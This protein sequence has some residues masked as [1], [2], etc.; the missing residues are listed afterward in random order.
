MEDAVTVLTRSTASV[1]SDALDR[2]G[3]RDQTLDPAIRPLAPGTVLAGRAV[4]IRVVVS[5]R[6]A[7]PPYG[8]EIQAL[9]DLRPGEVPVY[10]TEV[11]VGAAL[12]G[13][14][15]TCAALGRGA[16]GAVLDGPVRDARQIRELGFPVFSRGA[17]PLDTLGR[18]EVE[19]YRVPAVCG[20]VPIE[21]GDVVVADDDVVVVVPQAAVAE[22]AAIVEAKLRDERSARADLL[23][24]A[25]LGEV[26]NRYGVL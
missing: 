25:T 18:A 7:D 10:C 15:F 5:A 9:D 22:V 2:L 19:A 8:T 20:G 24:G 3:H 12:W 13:E 16:A 11:G 23:A 6:A 21:P 4:P 17:S 14:L 26:W 1:V